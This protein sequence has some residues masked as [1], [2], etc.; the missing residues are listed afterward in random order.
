MCREPCLPLAAIGASGTLERVNAE[1]TATVVRIAT[2]LGIAAD[3]FDGWQGEELALYQDTVGVSSSLAAAQA[4]ARRKA[5][6]G[7]WTLDLG[8]RAVGLPRDQGALLRQALEDAGV[9]IENRSQA[10]K[11]IRRIHAVGAENADVLR[12]LAKR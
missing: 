8:I 11:Y 7:N 10:S 2:A 5:A 4:E 12:E 6:L 9:P 1:Q 3:L